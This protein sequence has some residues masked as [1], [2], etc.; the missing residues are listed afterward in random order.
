MWCVP[1]SMR[2]GDNYRDL[3]DMGMGMIG[4][5]FDRNDGVDRNDGRIAG[6]GRWALAAT[7][8]VFVGL[9]V[10]LVLVGLTM[11]ALGEAGNG[12]VDRYGDGFR[13]G[14][15]AGTKINLLAAKQVTFTGQ[16]TRTTSLPGALPG[17]VYLYLDGWS[18]S[19]A[20]PGK[21]VYAVTTNTIT[22]TVAAAT[23][24]TLNLLVVGLAE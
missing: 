22:V 5:G 10:M 17:D 23:T 14:S 4:K 21:V 19:S 16:T 18:S 2:P 6:M 11:S 15:D 12:R 3:G 13:I 7:W 8:S 1:W 9:V 24:G 20:D